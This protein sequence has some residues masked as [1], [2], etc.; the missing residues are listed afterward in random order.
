MQVPGI[1]WQVN[2]QAREFL[3]ASRIEDHSLGWAP[4]NKTGFCSLLDAAGRTEPWKVFWGCSIIGKSIATQ[5]RALGHIM[6]PKLQIPFSV[7]GIIAITRP[8]ILVLL[9]LSLPV[10]MLAF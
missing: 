7:Y 5:D 4:T 1:H 3:P 2:S 6:E 9:P 8:S 10:N